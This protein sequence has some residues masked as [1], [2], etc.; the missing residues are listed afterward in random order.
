MYIPTILVVYTLLNKENIMLYFCKLNNK[1]ELCDINTVEKFKLDIIQTITKEEYAKHGSSYY[2][3]DNKICLGKS[4]EQILNELRIEREVQCFQVINRG[5]LWYDNLTDTQ[6]QELKVWYN[7]WLDVTETKVI[8]TK[9]K[10]L[11]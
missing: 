4:D 7:A 11:V 8:P 5:Q 2:I 6:K 1:I 3:K 9:P 10:W